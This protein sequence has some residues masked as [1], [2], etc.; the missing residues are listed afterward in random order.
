MTSRAERYAAAIRRVGSSDPLS[1][2]MKQVYRQFRMSAIS[3]V[4][5]NRDGTATKETMCLFINRKD[6]S[7][8]GMRMVWDIRVINGAN[9]YVG[10]ERII[11]SS[12]KGVAGHDQIRP[13]NKLFRD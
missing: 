6:H 2:I 5:Y 9:Y 7:V 13:N 3:V 8:L 1:R 11:I 12:V 10:D 4:G